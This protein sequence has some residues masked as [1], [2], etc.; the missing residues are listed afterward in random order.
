MIKKKKEFYS[1]REMG[2]MV[3]LQKRQLINR[4]KK[5]KE[6]YK[7]NKQLLSFEGRSWKIH[8]TLRFEFDRV[9]TTN[10]EKEQKFIS[11]VSINPHGNYDVAYNLELVN[12]AYKEISTASPVPVRIQYFIEQGELG[13]DYHTHF[14]INLTP[15]YQKLIKRAASVYTKT[16]TDVRYI[17]E[18]H[19][20]MDYLEKDVTVQGFLSS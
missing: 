19:Q 9:K 5:V 7:D 18:E 15:D 10:T 14:K 8:W 2:E 13:K 16:N 3:D 1:L 20:L 6:K 12:K 17:Y 11:L 4:M